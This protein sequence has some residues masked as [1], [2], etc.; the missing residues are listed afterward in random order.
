[1]KCISVFLQNICLKINMVNI[2]IYKNVIF[3]N[4]CGRQEENPQKSSQKMYSH[5]SHCCLSEVWVVHQL[6]EP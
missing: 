4:S 1:M 3:Q 5:R 2:C 6:S